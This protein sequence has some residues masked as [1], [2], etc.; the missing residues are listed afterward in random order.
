M[1]IN[2]GA[3]GMLLLVFLLGGFITWGL[4]LWLLPQWLQIP[5]A[6]IAGVVS[7]LMYAIVR[8]G[9]NP[10]EDLRDRIHNQKTRPRK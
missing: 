7:A 1:K 9:D 4:A 10:M 5:S 3:V 6:L 8:S 2:W